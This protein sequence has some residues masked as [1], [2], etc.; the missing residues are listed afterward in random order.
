MKMLH[1][2][3]AVTPFKPPEKTAN[4]LL[5]SQQIKTY[6]PIGVIKF[7][8]KGISDLKVGNKVLYKVY[9]SVDIDED[10]VIVPY[11]SVVAVMEA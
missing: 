6:P 10:T 1:N 4:G 8:P 7:L 11:T 9:A 3:I 2:Y 5:L